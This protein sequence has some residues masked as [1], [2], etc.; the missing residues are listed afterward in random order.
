[1]LGMVGSSYRFSDSILVG[2]FLAWRVFASLALFK[3][4]YWSYFSDQPAIV[5]DLKELWTF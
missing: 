2:T 5:K 3:S 4:S 1:M